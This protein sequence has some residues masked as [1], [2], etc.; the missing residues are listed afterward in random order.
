[1]YHEAIEARKQFCKYL[2]KVGTVDHQIRRAYAEVVCLH[3]LAGEKF[4][5]KTVLEEFANE[6]P[7]AMT[8]DEYRLGEAIMFAIAQEGMSSILDEDWRNLQ[9]TLKKP[10][11]NFLNNEIVRSMKILCLEKIEK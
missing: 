8:K 10:L 7:G 4:K 2:I 1:M 11:F 3:I 6:V 5:V 9:A